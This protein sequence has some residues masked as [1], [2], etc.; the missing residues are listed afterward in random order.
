[1]DKYIQ[2]E[3]GGKLREKLASA[4]IKEVIQSSGVTVH[5]RRAVD[6][7]LRYFVQFPL[8]TVGGLIGEP[9]TIPAAHRPIPRGR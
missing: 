6:D 7:W 8:E 9:A 3:V 4:G 5:P 2:A 1:M